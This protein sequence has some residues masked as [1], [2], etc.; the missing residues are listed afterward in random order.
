MPVKYSKISDYKIKKII[1][2]FCVELTA[3]Q[4]SVLLQINRNT[5]NRYYLMFRKVIFKKQT[6]DLEKF[7]GIVEMDESYFG[8]NRIRGH[9]G[10]R[11]H[12]RGTIRYRTDSNNSYVE[13][14]MQTGAS[15]YSW[16]VINQ[17]TW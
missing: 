2:C 12:G 10:K 7:V 14:C 6:S 8:A 4:T 13:M 15:T 3:T 9:R 1:R 16:I 17:N 11:K 5:I